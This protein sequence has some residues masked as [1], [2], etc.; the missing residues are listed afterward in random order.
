LE[1][2]QNITNAMQLSAMINPQGMGITYD[3]EA[4]DAELGDKLGVPAKFIRDKEDREILKQQIQQAMIAERNE[5]MS[6]EA[7]KEIMVNE[8]K[9]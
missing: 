3:V 1:D 5:Q 2:V 8:A 6:A 9:K 7:G 4:I